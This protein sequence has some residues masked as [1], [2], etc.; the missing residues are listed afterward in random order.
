MSNGYRPLFSE[1]HFF[2]NIFQKMTKNFKFSQKVGYFRNFFN[3]KFESS[4]EVYYKEMDNLIEF[5]EGALP[6]DNVSD[7]T[8]NLLV[9]GDRPTG[10]GHCMYG[11][12]GVFGVDSWYSKENGKLLK[13][14]F[15]KRNCRP[16]DYKFLSKENRNE[17]KQ[18]F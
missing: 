12:V 3:D 18:K 10:P 6:G 11:G 15:V 14:V 2:S 17:R 13:Q 1:I 5:K 7:N 4:V 8:D 16:Y 9:F